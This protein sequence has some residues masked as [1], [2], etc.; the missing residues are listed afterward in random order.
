[1]P[2]TTTDFSAVSSALGYLYQVRYALHLLLEAE[3][4][5]EVTLEKLDDVAFDTKGQPA[6][7]LQ[8]KHHLG[9]TASLT[10]GSS[11][12]WKTLRVWSE[13]VQ[14]NKAQFLTGTLMLVT[15]G[16]AAE[17]SAAKALRGG[18]ER[19]V[20][21]ALKA[22][23]EVAMTSQNQENKAAYASF[24][25]LTAE[26][27][28][29]LLEHVYVLDQAPDVGGVGSLIEKQ[30]RLAAPE[31]H[32]KGFCERLEGWWL[33]RVISMWTTPGEMSPVLHRELR[34]F[35]DDLRGQFQ[36]ENL[37]ADFIGKVVVDE[38]DLP[39]NG[40]LF[41]AQLRSI[42]VGPERIQDALS[43]FFRAFEQRSR[44]VREE[45]VWQGEIEQ[46]EERLL[47]AWRNLYQAMKDDGE[48]ASTDQV[49]HAA[50]ALYTALIGTPN[51]HLPIRSQFTHPY[52]MR[53]SYHMLANLPRLCWHPEWEAKLIQQK[54]QEA[55][56]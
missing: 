45:L 40:S 47:D 3:P 22:L 6:E 14:T 52:V 33:R 39:V 21:A 34:L 25:R 27:Q 56:L 7:L 42:K 44:W 32:L 11:D 36:R 49:T 55:G 13:G 1:M 16:T 43:D 20:P 41:L 50:R 48:G 8:F 35:L 28:R 51:N 54:Q 19:N 5:A 26:Q 10:D 29:T 38:G 12:V 2:A 23:R 24:G 53:G 4:D 30:V 31:K 17:Q 18:E 9:K 15:T 37:P 46:Y